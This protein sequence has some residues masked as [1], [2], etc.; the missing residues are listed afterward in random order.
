LTDANGISNLDF[1]L[2]FFMDLLDFT[3]CQLGRLDRVSLFYGDGVVYLDY[4]LGDVCD[5]LTFFF[6]NLVAKRAVFT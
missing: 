6:K 5:V 4:F 3:Q 2:V 1:V